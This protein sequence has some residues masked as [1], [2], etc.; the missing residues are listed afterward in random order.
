[1]NVA[2]GHKDTERFMTN[3]AEMGDKYASVGLQILLFPSDQFGDS[4]TDKQYKSLV[5]KRQ[6]GVKMMGKVR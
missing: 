4:A 3:I 6:E 2:Y 5:H 1:M